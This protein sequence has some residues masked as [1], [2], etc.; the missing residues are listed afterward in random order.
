MGA[1]E[2]VMLDPPSSIAS[3]LCWA[4]SVAR[5]RSSIDAIEQI[6][7]RLGEYVTTVPELRVIASPLLGT[8]AGRLSDLE[9]A[10]ALVRGF[11]HTPPEHAI[12]RIHVLNP[13]T[14]DQLKGV[15]PAWAH[16]KWETVFIS[17]GGPDEATA[18]RINDALNAR[19]VETWF[20]PDDAIPGD[21]LHRVMYEGVN[22]H[23]RVLLLCSEH[24]LMRSGVMNELERVLEREAKEGGRGILLPVSIDD[25]VFS[26][27]NFPRADM[28]AQIRSR[29][30]ADLRSSLSS[31]E[32]FEEGMEKIIK[33]LEK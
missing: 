23:D 17:Y 27:R 7:R 24:S 12:L 16:G 18:S 28:L 29:V 13:V 15:L 19:G 5:N 6:G 4:T 20:F 8:G 2:F 26:D 9:S 32:E 33:A 10:K 21:K 3:V 31:V 14:F 1:T 30:I 25:F 22:R 11:T